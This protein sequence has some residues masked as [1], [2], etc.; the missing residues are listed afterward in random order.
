MQIKY[1]VV[2]VDNNI[3]VVRTKQWLCLSL[4]L[5]RFID[6]I[7]TEAL[8]SM[9]ANNRKWR[10][11][12]YIERKIVLITFRF[13]SE[14]T[15]LEEDSQADLNRKLYYCSSMRK[16]EHARLP[17]IGF[18]EAF[19]VKHIFFFSWKIWNSKKLMQTVVT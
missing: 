8:N 17:H 3:S 16:R 10:N 5:L 4:C 14:E 9:I 18:R 6:W 15:A 11:I 7:L 13:T 1:I 12:R 2:N 19:E